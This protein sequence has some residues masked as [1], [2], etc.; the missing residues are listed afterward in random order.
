MRH[1][2]GRGAAGAPSVAGERRPR[3][4]SCQTS[5]R[6][7]IRAGPCRASGT[8][9]GSA[10]PAGAS[11]GSVVLQRVNSPGLSQS[12]RHFCVTEDRRGRC[13][14]G[15]GRVP[16]ARVCFSENLAAVAPK[17]DRP[18]TTRSRACTPCLSSARSSEPEDPQFGC[19]PVWVLCFVVG[20]A[21]SQRPKRPMPKPPR[22]QAVDS[23]VLRRDET[24]SPRGPRT[25]GAP[26]RFPP[27]QCRDWQ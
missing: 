13:D 7:W 8:S 2:I 22:S 3:I 4:P 9:L 18:M 19:L 16:R 12:P 15:R 14:Q 25:R 6:A 27:P 1:S 24:P 11:E 26:T 5:N 17:T 20:S 10:T 21:S 23:R